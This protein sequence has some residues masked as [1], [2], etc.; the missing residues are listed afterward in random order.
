MSAESP[1]Y[2]AGS[3]Q[4]DSGALS[5]SICEVMLQFT[6]ENPAAPASRQES[7]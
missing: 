6:L 3:A 2:V 7:A 5:G 1:P 4:R